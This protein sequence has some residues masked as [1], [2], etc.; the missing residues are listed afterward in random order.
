MSYKEASA[1]EVPAKKG[2]H[3]MVKGALVGGLSAAIVSVMLAQPAPSNASATVLLS[4]LATIGNQ[5][6]QYLD[7]MTAWVDSWLPDLSG[8]LTDTG[9]HTAMGTSEA[10]KE[11]IQEATRS[12][13]KYHAQGGEP[14]NSTLT[15][16]LELIRSKDTGRIDP[17]RASAVLVPPQPIAGDNLTTESL[18]EAWNHALMMTGDEPLP[19]VRDTQRDSLRG[20]EYEY[21][22]VQALQTRL[23]AQDAIMNYPVQGPKL[24]GYREHLTQL[25]DN[26]KIAGLTPGQI[27]A[28]QLEM[29]VK[30]QLPAAIDNVESSLRQERLLGAL[31]AQEVKADVEDLIQNEL[32]R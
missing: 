20:N 10:A 7:T 29:A 1:T 3:D 24:H 26:N 18:E 30:I 8:I 15:N 12:S 9:W 17:E 14:Y 16:Q 23:L 31:L 11:S 25:V 28:A 27:A 32:G 19:E 21:K 4:P 2:R 6:N 22:R 13:S 5:I